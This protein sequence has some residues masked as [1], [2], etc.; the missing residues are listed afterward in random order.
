MKVYI[1][2][3]YTN[4]ILV[5]FLAIKSISLVQRLLNR[6]ETNKDAFN[7]FLYEHIANMILRLKKKR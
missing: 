2:H 4:S 7:T 5:L 6:H 1:S 3:F